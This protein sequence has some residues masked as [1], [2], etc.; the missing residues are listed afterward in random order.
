MPKRTLADISDGIL[1]R[2]DVLE[3]E[4]ARLVVLAKADSE[5]RVLGTSASLLY[6]TVQELRED[7]NE[8]LKRSSGT[9]GRTTHGGV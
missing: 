4:A 1:S 6:Q 2:L 5:N 7:I 9:Y 3:I 8:F